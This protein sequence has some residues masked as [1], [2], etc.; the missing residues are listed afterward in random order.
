MS[1][2]TVQRVNDFSHVAAHDSSMQSTRGRSHSSH[3]SRF[4][5]RMNIFRRVS[6]KDSQR[7]STEDNPNQR[8]LYRESLVQA[9]IREE[10][11]APDL[12]ISTEAMTA[13]GVGKITTTTVSSSLDNSATVRRRVKFRYGRHRRIHILNT[14]TSEDSVCVGATATAADT[15]DNIIEHKTADNVVQSMSSRKCF[16][17]VDHKL[18]L[19]YLKRT[20][21]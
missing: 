18:L 2:P 11:I 6:G 16:P 4:G 19:D 15:S 7:Q 14:M 10:I 20:N 3:T 9:L 21:N 5:R 8:T 1:S 13:P 17:F 12:T